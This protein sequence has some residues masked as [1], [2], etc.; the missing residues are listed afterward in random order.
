[1]RAEYGTLTYRRRLG[2]EKHPDVN[3]AGLG[4]CED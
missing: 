1:M 4:G 3:L 2:S